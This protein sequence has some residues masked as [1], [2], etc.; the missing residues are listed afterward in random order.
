ML[1]ILHRVGGARHLAVVHDRL[2]TEVAEDLLGHRPFAQISFGVADLDPGDLLPGGDALRQAGGDGRE[3]VGAG[4]LMGAA[5]QV[6]VDE[7]YLVSAAREPHGCGPAE[8]AV[9]AQDQ[10]AHRGPF[11]RVPGSSG[12][13][14]TGPGGPAAPAVR[15]RAGIRPDP[16]EPAAR[17]RPR[18]TSGSGR[19]RSAPRR[20]SPAAPGART[21]RW[22]SSGRPR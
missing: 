6:V 13:D 7:V 10:D 17:G 20:P 22:R 15:P 4:L 18:R 16:R 12:G 19:S 14:C 9:A 21:A 8:V 1:A 2:G 3:G 5:A 11:R